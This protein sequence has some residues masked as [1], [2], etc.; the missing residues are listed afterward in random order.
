MNSCF[1]SIAPVV[2]TLSQLVSHRGRSDL[3]ETIF[4]Q[5]EALHLQVTI[6]FSRSGAIALMPLGLPLQ[7]EFLA[8]SLGNRDSAGATAGRFLIGTSRLHTAA[9]QMIYT[10]AIEVQPQHAGFAAEQVY[11]VSALLRVGASH[12]PAWI[13]GTIGGLLTQTY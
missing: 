4:S 9:H 12:Q 7:V 6:E 5:T 3:P 10:A 8:E 11:E 1:A 2:C 13:V